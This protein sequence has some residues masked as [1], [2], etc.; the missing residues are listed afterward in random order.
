VNSFWRALFQH[1]ARWLRETR[2]A[3]IIVA[4]GAAT[5]ASAQEA[6]ERDPADDVNTPLPT[7]ANIGQQSIGALLPEPLAS[8]NGLRPALARNG[9]AF[10]FT[11]QADPMANVSGG[12]RTGASYI[13]RVQA[14]ADF[15]PEPLTGWKGALF[16][17]SY[18]QIHGVGLT[19]AFIGSFASVSDID[20]LA[21]LRL[22]EVW[23][24]QKLS[25]WLSLRI[26]QLAVDTEFFLTPYL[27]IG[28]GGTFGW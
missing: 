14:A 26:G 25:D 22:N 2:L 3:A 19:G 18:Y 7:A 5:A 20:A 10:A 12:L 21:T 24:E 17:S 1:K 11:Y 28:I 9:F 4:I 8:W 15:D 6:S 13:G 27:G 23:V 16:H